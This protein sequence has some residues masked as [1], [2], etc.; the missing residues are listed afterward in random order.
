MPGSVCDIEVT[1][2]VINNDDKVTPVEFVVVPVELY[3]YALSENFFLHQ[4]Q[5][6]NTFTT[7]FSTV[8]HNGLSFI[9]QNIHY[10]KYEVW[11]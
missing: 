10:L 6:Q 1:V 9:R 5:F 8:F 3:Q 11:P 7:V 4:K 2:F